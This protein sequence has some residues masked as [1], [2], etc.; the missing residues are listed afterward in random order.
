[1]AQALVETREIKAVYGNAWM[2]GKWYICNA[3]HARFT[4][5][6]GNKDSSCPICAASGILALK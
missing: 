2:Q 4:L 5:P 6:A 3:C 1:M